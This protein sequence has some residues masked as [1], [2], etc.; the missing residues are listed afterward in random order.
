M[1]HPPP[2]FYANIAPG[3]DFDQ[4]SPSQFTPAYLEGWVRRLGGT[5]TTLGLSFAFSLLN[6][7]IPKLAES[8]AALRRAAEETGIHVIP[9]FD[10]QNWWDFRGDLWNWFDPNRPGYSPTNRENVEWMGP[11]PE[12]ATQKAWRNWGTQIRVAPPPNL[13]SKAYRSAGEAALSAVI[14]P[15][16][17]WLATEPYGTNIC[18]PGIK[19]GWEAS[20][21]VNAYV[22]PQQSAID[23]SRPQSDPTYGL[24]HTK[25]LFGG[26]APL[27]WAALHSAGRKS[28]KQIGKSD[29]EWIVRD[30]LQWMVDTARH[31]G[32]SETQI[33]THAGGQFHPYEEHISH[34]VACV[35]GAAPG[36]SLYNI[37]PTAA[38]DLVQAVNQR[39]DR[40]WC[41]AEWMSFAPSPEQWADDLAATLAV[42]KCRFLV[43]YNAQDLLTNPIAKSGL[44]LAIMQGL[45][46][47]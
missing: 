2:R 47:G 44:K 27:G 37:R 14:K 3:Q 20:L 23:Q 34:D 31:C 36:W 16:A 21:G 19:L 39:R 8:T 22:Y 29:I 45:T 17:Q 38:G 5:P 25:G 7:P 24:D 43:A 18:T 6:G 10:I 35:R 26:L 33:Y 9:A 11:G 15:W 32:L 4:H 30:Y 42:G 1:A 41:C 28:R 12:F 13:R 40:R 46:R